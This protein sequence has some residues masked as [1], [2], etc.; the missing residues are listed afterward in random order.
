MADLPELLQWLKSTSTF[1][2]AGVWVLVVMA[3]VGWWKG[4]PAV[5]LAW[6]TRI[7]AEAERT[8]K[9][10]ARLE[11]QI[12]AGERR[13]ADCEDRCMSLMKRLDDQDETIR[14]LRA[15]MSQLQVS[16]VRVGMGP[17]SV[18]ETLIASLDRV[19]GSDGKVVELKPRL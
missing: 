8:D 3:A 1:G 11:R 15:Q 17:L 18:T 2:G 9:E 4:L 10:I 12:A 16:A 19:P 13:H 6:S 5:L 7:G 14:G